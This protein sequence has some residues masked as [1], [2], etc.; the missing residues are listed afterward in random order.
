MEIPVKNDPYTMRRGSTDFLLESSVKYNRV[1]RQ[2]IDDDLAGWALFPDGI[3]VY[4]A[5]FRTSEFETPRGLA[6]VMCNADFFV[7]GVL[8]VPV[9]GWC[10]Q[11]VDEPQP[12]ADIRQAEHHHQRYNQT[13]DK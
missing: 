4:R 13:G 11:G 7:T 5:D 3:A 1:Q 2:K 9:V 8:T 12:F 10:R 6:L